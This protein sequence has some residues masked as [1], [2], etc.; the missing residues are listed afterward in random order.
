MAKRTKS[1][2]NKQIFYGRHIYLDKKN[3]HVYY[4]RFNKNGYLIPLDKAGM[5]NLYSFRLVYSAIIAIL[6]GD[7]INGKL[8]ML[9]VVIG[10]IAYAG[11][12]FF[13]RM[14]FLPSLTRYANFDTKSAKGYVEILAEQDSKKLILLMIMYVVLAVLLIFIGIEKQYGVTSIVILAGLALYILY[15]AFGYL[16][17]LIYQSKQK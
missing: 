4:N 9:A 5:Y 3:R 12:E 16:Q 8:D 2:Q 17:A 11:F 6:L 7:M 10:V 13:Y 15:N 1:D 14:R